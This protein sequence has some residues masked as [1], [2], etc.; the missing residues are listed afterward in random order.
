ML[1]VDSSSLPS[2]IWLSVLHVQCQ[3][4]VDLAWHYEPTTSV[5]R[6][7]AELNFRI[8]AGSIGI[9][10]YNGVHK[11]SGIPLVIAINH[12]GAFEIQPCIMQMLRVPCHCTAPIID[13][14]G[15]CCLCSCTV[16]GEQL[17]E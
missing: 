16:I 11:C 15:H 10:L 5:C 13:Q 14:S 4:L 8:P 9:N 7:Q 12:Y 2:L 1:S 3:T 6:T 17:T